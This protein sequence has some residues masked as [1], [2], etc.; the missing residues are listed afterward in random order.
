[1]DNETQLFL[2]YP[3]LNIGIK[4]TETKPVVE[5]TDPK[6]Q[7]QTEIEKTLDHKNGP[8]KIQKLLKF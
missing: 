5:S 8:P 4:V 7:N 1:M 2:D 6:N 3:L